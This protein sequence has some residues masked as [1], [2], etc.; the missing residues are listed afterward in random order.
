M[1]KVGSNL[2]IMSIFIR[3]SVIEHDSEGFNTVFQRRMQAQI[4]EPFYSDAGLMYCIFVLYF[5]CQWNAVIVLGFFNTHIDLPFRFFTCFSNPLV[6]ISRK[7][8]ILW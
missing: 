2:L 3:R 5:L 4:F 8:R 1:Y 6:F 7:D